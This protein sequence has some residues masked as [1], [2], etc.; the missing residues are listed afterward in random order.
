MTGALFGTIDPVVGDLASLD[1]VVLT[2]SRAVFSSL[3]PD[4]GVR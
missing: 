1:R 3:A 2:I 4:S